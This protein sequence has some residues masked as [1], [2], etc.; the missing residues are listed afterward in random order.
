MTK[1]QYEAAQDEK[2]K[3]DH[4][5]DYEKVETYLEQEFKTYVQDKYPHENGDELYNNP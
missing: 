4:P 3:R 5:E 1:E 2:H